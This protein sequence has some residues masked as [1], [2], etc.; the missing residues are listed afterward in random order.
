MDQRGFNWLGIVSF[1]VVVLL[2]V[3]VDALVL[4]LFFKV[5][6][7]EEE[8]GRSEAESPVR[9]RPHRELGRDYLDHACIQ[10]PLKCHVLIHVIDCFC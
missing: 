6:P 10:P 7:Q 4:V 2:V 8:R 1:V 3:I 9:H 5:P